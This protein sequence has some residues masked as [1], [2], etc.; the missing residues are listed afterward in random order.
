MQTNLDR[1]WLVKPATLLLAAMAVASG[2]Y[3][4]LKI[5]GGGFALPANVAVAS[6]NTSEADS[7]ALAQALGAGSRPVASPSAPALASRFVLLGVLAGRTNAGAALIAIDGKPAR[8]YRVGAELES[9]LVLQWV[10]GRQAV[11]ASDLAGPPVLTLELPPLKPNL[12]A[13]EPQDAVGA[14]DADGT[15]P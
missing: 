2:A 12:L 13:R 6:A 5:T 8:P 9:G 14:P 7:Q 10:K 1:V 4:A 15:Q 11:L 3:W